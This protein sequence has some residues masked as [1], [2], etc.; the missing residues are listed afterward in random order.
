MFKSL[1]CRMKKEKDGKKNRDEGSTSY[2]L[3]DI[4][5]PPRDISMKMIAEQDE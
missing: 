2:Y 5:I 4:R 1:W 3:R